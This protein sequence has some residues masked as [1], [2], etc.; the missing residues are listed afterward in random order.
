M[1]NKKILP[2][3]PV[4]FFILRERIKVPNNFVSK[5]INFPKKGIKILSV[6]LYNPLII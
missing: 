2:E 5:V 4:Y 3:I 1:P 6:I